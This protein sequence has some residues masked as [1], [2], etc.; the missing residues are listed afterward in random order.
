MDKLGRREDLHRVV[1]AAAR[2]WSDL[3]L[4]VLRLVASRVPL[5]DHPHMSLVCKTWRRSVRQVYPADR[6]PVLLH[7]KRWGSGIFHCYSPLFNKTFVLR[8]P[9]DLSGTKICSARDGWLMLRRNSQVILANPIT[10]VAHHLALP[11]HCHYFM[12]VSFAGPPSDC[13]VF[14]IETFIPESVRISVYRRGSWASPRTYENNCRF[15][16]SPRSNPVYHRGSFY[17][18]GSKGELGV[19]DPEKD[20]WTVLAKPINFY[21]AKSSNCG[22]SFLIESEGE[23]LSVLTGKFGR[24]VRVFRLNEV[25]MVWEKIESLVGRRRRSLF[26]RSAMSI[27]STPSIDHRMNNKVY[28]PRVHGEPEI[29]ESEVERSGDRIF[30]V[31]KCSSREGDDETRR[32][33]EGDH[34]GICCCDLENRK[35]SEYFGS[36]E[37]LYSIWFEPRLSDD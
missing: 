33:N 19:Y 32:R 17:C 1:S 34:G 7:Y 8:C 29:I 15:K 28:F 31:P 26:V 3:P 16:I 10:G 4:D 37:Y 30:F 20:T 36:N 14:A 13:T 23:L 21:P 35:Y 2:S 27:S 18:L 22:E 24:R 5:P 12:Y 25:D 6:S 11:Q 9:A